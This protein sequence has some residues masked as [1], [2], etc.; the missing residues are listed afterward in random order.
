[1]KRKISQLN[2]KR[3][4]KQS[5]VKKKKKKEEEKSR[6]E[7]ELQEVPDYL[8]P[9]L[10]IIFVGF[11]PGLRSGALGRHYAGI[12]NQF[13]NLLYLSSLSK[14]LTFVHQITN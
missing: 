14:L 9:E 7:K 4:E 11:N 3:K 8:Q 1:M 13:Y 12:N 5:K 10:D 6:T 2:F